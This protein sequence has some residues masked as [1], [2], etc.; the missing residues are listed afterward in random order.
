M[1]YHQLENKMK[2]KTKEESSTFLILN[3]ME[4]TTKAMK[5]ATVIAMR[6]I[7]SVEKKLG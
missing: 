5:R 6:T 7:K 4:T 2:K 3:K 1:N